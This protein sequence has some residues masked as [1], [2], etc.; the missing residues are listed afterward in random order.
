MCTISTLAVKPVCSE[1]KK[2]ASSPQIQ[3]SKTNLYAKLKVF[4]INVSQ[5]ILTT[6]NALL[7]IFLSP[8]K[9]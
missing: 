5:K 1:E 7:G 2:F 9:K 6:K 4:K 3:I 8:T